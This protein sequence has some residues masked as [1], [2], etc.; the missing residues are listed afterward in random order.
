MV[1]GVVVVLEELVLE[2]ELV[3]DVVENIRHSI[4]PWLFVVILTF[5]AVVTVVDVAFSMQGTFSG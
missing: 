4:V 5:T 2:R 1:D 3:V